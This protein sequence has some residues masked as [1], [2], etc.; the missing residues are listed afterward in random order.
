MASLSDLAILAGRPFRPMPALAASA[1]NH[2]IST[3]GQIAWV[4]SSPPRRMVR[5][6]F[7]TPRL[8]ITMLVMCAPMSMTA[9]TES[10]SSAMERSAANEDR[11]T[12]ATLSPAF[13]TAWTA[14]R[15]GC[16]GVATSRPLT[17]L[18]SGFTS[19]S[20]VKSISTWSIGSATISRAWKGSAF[21]R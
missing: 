17:V 2:G 15:T 21:A 7:G 19:P 10:C 5:T 3:F 14:A 20:W 4:S 13:S 16:R 9:S 18:V 8:W 12:R 1:S 11:S 6:T